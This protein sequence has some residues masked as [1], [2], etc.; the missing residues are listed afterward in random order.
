MKF[1]ALSDEELN[2]PLYEEGEYN[3]EIKTAED[4]ESKSGNPM[5]K[6]GILVNMLNGRSL[7]VYDYLLCTD[8]S[9]WKISQLCKSIGKEGLYKSENI[10]PADLIGCF[11][12]AELKHELNP[13]DGKK[14]L[15]VKRYIKNTEEKI[16]EELNDD[17][18]F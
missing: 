16:D 7:L 6:I 14:Y 13:S 5:I 3:F 1:R 2:P 18:P 8:N 4:K 9:I 10:E 17:I 11:G 15:R 12:W